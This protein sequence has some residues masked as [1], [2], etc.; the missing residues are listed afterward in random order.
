MAD[1]GTAASGPTI[2]WDDIGPGVAYQRVKLSWG[3]DGSAVDAS[4]TNPLPTTLQGVTGSAPL[5]VQPGV[6]VR[7]SA[8]F[9][10]PADTTAYASGDTVA[11][12]TTAGSV[13]PLTFSN[14]VRTAGGG[15]MVRRVKL[16]KSGT[17][18]TNASFRLYL[19]SATQT[20]AAGDNAA[21]SLPGIADYLGSFEIVMDRA[22]TDGACGIGIPAVGS[23]ISLDIPSTGT[24]IYGFLEA[25]AAYAP[26][27]AEVF[28]V[29]LE[30]LQD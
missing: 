12:S 4:A 14:V 5:P 16:R 27:N 26:G 13:T 1:N 25:R 17:S 24:T 22:F 29:E 8:N 9:T 28:T 20:S 3:V 15:G 23:E 11:N 10:R 18:I 21:L 19:F 6:T 7:V 30:I 2:A